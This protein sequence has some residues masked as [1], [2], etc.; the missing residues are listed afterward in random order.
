MDSIVSS[1]RVLN[2]TDLPAAFL[3]RDWGAVDVG[4]HSSN[5]RP[6]NDEGCVGKAGIDKNYTFNQV[7]ELAKGCGANIIVKAGKNA[8]RYLKR[9]EKEKI[10]EN[11]EKQT[12]RDTSRCRMFQIE[13]E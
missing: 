8:K 7:V 9:C 12:W 3:V 10:R 13:W 1:G 6:V 4:Y 2:S 11:I 5:I